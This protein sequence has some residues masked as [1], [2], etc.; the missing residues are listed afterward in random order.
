MSQ[1][2]QHVVWSLE[3]EIRSGKKLEFMSFMSEVVDVLQRQP[4]TM[5]YEWTLS[6]DGSTAYVFERY[7]DEAAARGAIAAT[8]QLAERLPLLARS[9][10]FTVFSHV[11]PELK[12][13]LA[14]FSPVYMKPMGGFVAMQ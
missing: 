2:C 10:K 4:G 9:L 11:S 1:Q 6:K 8:R 13:D 12:A 3:G 7:Q 5:L 14:K